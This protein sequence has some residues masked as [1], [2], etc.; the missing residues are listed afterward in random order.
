[1]CG[2]RLFNDDDKSVVYKK[3]QKCCYPGCTI[4][5]YNDLEKDHIT[6]WSKG[7]RT[8]VDNLQLLCKT[9]N[10]AKGVDEDG[11]KG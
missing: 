4:T 6:P 3:S 1:M 9:H 10:A 11:I 7:G 5:N 8:I 2:K